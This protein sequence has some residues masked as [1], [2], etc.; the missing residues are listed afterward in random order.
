MRSKSEVVGT[1][2]SVA[3][4]LESIKNQASAFNLVSDQGTPHTKDDTEPPIATARRSYRARG[5]IQR[6]NND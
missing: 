4:L 3:Q 1:L 6:K 2:P 5:T